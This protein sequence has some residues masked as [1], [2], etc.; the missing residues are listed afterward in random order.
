[1]YELFGAQWEAIKVLLPEAAK[2]DLCF[3]KY[4][5]ISKFNYVLRIDPLLA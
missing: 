1:M 5:E 2:T 4:A 3:L